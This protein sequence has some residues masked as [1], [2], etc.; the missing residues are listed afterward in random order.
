MEKMY[1]EFLDYPTLAYEIRVKLMLEFFEEHPEYQMQD[2]EPITGG[3]RAYYSFNG[4][5]GNH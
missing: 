1:L 4:C 2:F 3:I 5:L